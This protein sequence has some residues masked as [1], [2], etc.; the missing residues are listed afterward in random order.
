MRTNARVLAVFC[1][2]LWAGQAPAKPP[3][4]DA[5]RVVYDTSM[6]WEFTPVTAE[7]LHKADS[8]ALSYLAKGWL[9]VGDRTQADIL[10]NELE[11]RGD[12]AFGIGYA[13]AAFSPVKK[14]ENPPDTVYV[15]TLVQVADAY[16]VGGRT[17]ALKH[18][19]EVLDAIP[20]TSGGRCLA[21]SKYDVEA[22]CLQDINLI[23]MAFL[24]RVHRNIDRE[25]AFSRETMLEPGAWRFWEEAPPG[26][27][28]YHKIMDA[29]HLGWS[30]YELL[31][32][33]DPRLQKLGLMAANYL[34]RTYDASKEPYFAPFA[35]AAAEVSAGLPAGCDRAASLPAW[36]KQNADKDPDRKAR[37]WAAFV[38]VWA[39][40]GCGTGTPRLGIKAAP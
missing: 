8:V 3:R 13:W 27:W 36:A 24:S 9:L 28:A 29:G 34:H 19:L 15:V 14:T 22:G 17:R 6:L 7:D 38:H 21:N 25:F 4:T 11:S 37:Q 16:R 5:E 20:L 18:A 33:N 32:T 35:V 10:L 39:Q 2:L 30:A 1:C 40:Q 12:E 31:Q 26:Y 23:G